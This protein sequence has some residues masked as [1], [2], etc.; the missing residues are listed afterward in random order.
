MAILGGDVTFIDSVNYLCSG[1]ICGSGVFCG[2]SI[3]A[4][5]I[6]TGYFFNQSTLTITSYKLP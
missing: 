2:C 4:N 3:N 6:A 1:D 5:S